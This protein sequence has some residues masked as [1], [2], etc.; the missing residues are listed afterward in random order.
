MVRLPVT[1]QNKDYGI[2]NA[3]I[4][5]LQSGQDKERTAN[6]GGKGVKAKR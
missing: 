6:G 4:C 5:F 2:G 3:N 1:A